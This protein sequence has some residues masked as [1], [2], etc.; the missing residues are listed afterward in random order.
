MSGK[1]LSG[2]QFEKICQEKAAKAV[3]SH[4]K[5]TKNTFFS[6]NVRG[7][8]DVNPGPLVEINKYESKKILS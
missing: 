4:R 7:P 3:E 1:K 8:D 5:N 6:S 2:H